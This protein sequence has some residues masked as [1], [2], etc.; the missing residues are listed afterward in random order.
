MFELIKYF[1]FKRNNDLIFHIEGYHYGRFFDNNKKPTKYFLQF[2]EMQ[3]VDKHEK[4]LRESVY[5]E[6]PSC[7][8]EWSDKDGT[9][10]WCSDKRYEKSTE[11]T[12]YVFV[13]VI[14]PIIIAVVEFSVHGRV[15]PFC[16]KKTLKN[17]LVVPVSG[18]PNW[19]TQELVCTR[20]AT[21]YP[22]DATEFR[23]TSKVHIPF[24]SSHYIPR[25]P[26]YVKYCLYFHILPHSKA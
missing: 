20:D 17:Q 15:T 16:S 7:N 22:I 23:K 9:N 4:A 25:N 18:N 12:H 13:D 26:S 1:L 10:V 5:K 14:H 24:L 8:V 2:I 19:M 21:I 3:E 6:F 11:N